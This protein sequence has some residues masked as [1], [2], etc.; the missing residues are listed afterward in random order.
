M[1]LGR[2]LGRAADAFR[3]RARALLTGIA[4]G[5]TPLAYRRQELLVLALLAASVLGGFAVDVWH[6]R[7]PDTLDR[8]EAE[9]PR[10]A[11]LA[12][13]P[14]PRP[15][16]GPTRPRDAPTDAGRLRRATPAAAGAEPGARTP[17]L[18]TTDRPLD[19]NRATAAE[20][21]GL[22][23]IGPGLAARIVA[24]RA[25]IGGRFDDIGDLAR[26]PGLGARKAGLVRAF[27]YVNPGLTEWPAP[28]ASS[29]DPDPSVETA[30]RTESPPPA[31]P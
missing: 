28:G 10:L 11:A 9:P 16:T 15:R 2:R 3:E 17:P 7:A 26:V 20:L 5:V 4:H 14:G 12:R 27:V 25:Q 22:P 8:L 13:S 21:T 30:D 24:R 29:G 1:R 23:G 18:P 6:R 19:L 31:P